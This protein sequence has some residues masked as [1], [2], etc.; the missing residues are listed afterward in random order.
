MTLDYLYEYAQNLHKAILKYVTC[1]VDRHCVKPLCENC[2]MLQLKLVLRQ[3]NASSM[4]C[5][6]VVKT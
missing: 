2:G 6:E 3:S 5:T 1:G 4:S